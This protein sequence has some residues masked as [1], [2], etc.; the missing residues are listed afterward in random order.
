VRKYR[1]VLS[2][3]KTFCHQNGLVLL[4]Q[5]TTDHLDEFRSTWKGRPIY[6]DGKIVDYKPKTQ[7]GKQRYQQNLTIFFNHAVHKE[8]ISKNPASKLTKIVVPETGDR[9]RP[10]RSPWNYAIRCSG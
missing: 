7:G 6:K 9:A 5:I 10:R 4:K 3:L 2:P 8:W 1:D